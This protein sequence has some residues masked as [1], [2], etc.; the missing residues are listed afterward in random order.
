MGWG[1]GGKTNNQRQLEESR[2]ESEG[3]R[4]DMASAREV[5]KQERMVGI[6]RESAG[7]QRWDYK[8]DE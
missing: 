4:L 7:L 3:I 6:A 1:E 5:G 8:E 2:A